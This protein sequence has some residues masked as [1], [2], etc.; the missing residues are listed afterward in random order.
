MKLISAINK[1]IIKKIIEIVFVLVFVVFSI[2]LWKSENAKNFLTAIS[3]SDYK[4]TNINVESPID[5]ELYPITDK[6]ALN[7]KPFKINVVNETYTK[8]YYNLALKIAKNSTL[9]INF[10]K[11][12]IANDVYNLIDLERKDDEL[13]YIFIL[14]K[15]YLVGTNKY[16]EIRLWLNT[17]ADNRMQNKEI[18]ME[19]ILTN[20]TTK[21]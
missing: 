18:N 14:D 21:I 20:Q 17:L 3:L 16:Y 13:Y 19:F 1:L 2:F 7:I 12:M 6:T 9:D 11:I 8:E 5:F 15:D 4:Y 10:L